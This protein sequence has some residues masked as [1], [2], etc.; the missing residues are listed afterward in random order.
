MSRKINSWTKNTL[1]G[2]ES[3][4]GRSLLSGLHSA[5]HVHVE[6]HH[7]AIVSTSSAKTTTIAAK[8]SSH[9]ETHLV[10]TLADPAKVNGVTATAKFESEIKKGVTVSEL[11]VQVEGAKPT[12]RID[13]Q[14]TDTTTGTHTSI[15]TIDVK[16]NGT[17]Q[18]KLKSNSLVLAAGS[19][20]TLVSKADNTVL[21]SGPFATRTS[22]PKG[23]DDHSGEQNETH[24]TASTDPSISLIGAA[25][26]ESETEHGLIVS[27][28]SVSVKG[29][30]PGTEVD[31]LLAPDATT[32]AVSVGKIT[33]GADGTGRLKFKSNAPTVSQGS[34][35]TLTGVNN[36]DGSAVTT[37]GTFGVSTSTKH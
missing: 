34:V 11:S 15:G 28:L 23:S 22:K 12:D 37:T 27:E 9:S 1:L 20:I 33:L 25:K 16:A 10:A 2:V 31:V 18:L 26:Y 30:K 36:L 24:L 13:V 4:E 32:P 19:E 14:I 3:L 17:G 6:D 21:A 35:L 8:S 5:A 29:G 7:P